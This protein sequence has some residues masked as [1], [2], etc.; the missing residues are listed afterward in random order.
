MP[1]RKNPA[2]DGLT[3]LEKR[4]HAAALA[5]PN[6]TLTGDTLAVEMSDVAIEEQ[7]VA[8]NGLLKKSLLNAQKG[9][10]GIQYVAVTKDEASLY[11]LEEFD[12]ALDLWMRMR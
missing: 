4:V 11:V 7:L 5:A 1:K 6:L 8:I 10:Q 12:A 2:G 3:L 9:P